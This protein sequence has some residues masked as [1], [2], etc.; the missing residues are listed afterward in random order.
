[1]AKIQEIPS[2]MY[3]CKELL[4]LSNPDW[5][6]ILVCRTNDF[7]TPHNSSLKFSIVRGMPKLHS[8]MVLN[9]LRKN[10]GCGFLKLLS[11]WDI[12]DGLFICSVLLFC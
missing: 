10:Y 3:T 2:Y 12:N 1:M 9:Q 6:T 7:T 11:P 8:L 4:F 5:H